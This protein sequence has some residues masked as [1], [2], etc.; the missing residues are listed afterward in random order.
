MKDVSFERY[1]QI[2]NLQ[3]VNATNY[4]E[5]HKGSRRS[6]LVNN[7]IV[8]TTM[9]GY[10]IELG[11]L[12]RDKF[13]SFLATFKK[14]LYSQINKNPELKFKEIRFDFSSREKKHGIWNDLP[15]G[16]DFWNLDLSSAY[17]Q[18]GYRLGY[19]SKPFF[20]KYIEQDEYKHAKRLCWT[21]LARHTER[22]YSLP[23]TYWI[24]GC[25][26]SFDQRIYDNVR[27]ELYSIIYEARKLV[28]FA[29]M[30]YNID[31]ITISDPAHREVIEKYFNDQGLIFKV[32]EG[33]KISE[34]EYIMSSRIKKF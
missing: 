15:I 34:K 29:E 20:K 7:R 5:I 32:K 30:E 24:I 19:I 25:D 6:L 16:T 14:G 27:N 21:F 22:H 33:M 10:E 11:T 4:S 2:L 9:T 23:D 26:N 28:D 31:G 3:Q 12:P 1:N 18:V 13:V 8:C 17:W